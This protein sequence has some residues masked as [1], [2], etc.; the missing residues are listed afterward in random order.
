MAFWHR[1]FGIH[2]KRRDLQDE[3]EAHLAMEIRERIEHGES[4]DEARLNACMI[5]ET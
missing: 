5:S 1:F 3:I 4:A 2:K